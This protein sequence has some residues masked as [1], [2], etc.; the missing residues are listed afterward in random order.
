MENRD[1][2]YLIFVIGVISGISH[3]ARAGSFRYFFWSTVCSSA[4]LARL[5]LVGARMECNVKWHALL[6]ALTVRT[7]KG[8]HE[9]DR[10]GH[11][12]RYVY[13]LNNSLYT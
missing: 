7:D 1:A 10:H 9:Y 12:T 4:T 2:V 8:I 11:K 6:F 3:C 5:E 13:S